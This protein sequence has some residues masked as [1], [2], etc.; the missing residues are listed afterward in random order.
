MFT[1]LALEV[2]VGRMDTGT[3][4]AHMCIRVWVCFPVNLFT[5]IS[6]QLK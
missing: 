1:R 5:F 2:K 3:L 6:I 4:A